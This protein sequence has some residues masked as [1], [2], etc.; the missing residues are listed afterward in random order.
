MA[1]KTASVSPTLAVLGESFHRSLLAENKSPMTVK[2][3]ME[4]LRLF[5]HYVADNGMPREALN[6]RREHVEA[7]IADVL[8]HWKPS[9]ASNR[10]RSLQPPR[11]YGALMGLANREICTC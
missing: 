9:T 8:A 5:D 10:Y 7:F 4:A 6:L 2:A 3:Y 1:T 11:L